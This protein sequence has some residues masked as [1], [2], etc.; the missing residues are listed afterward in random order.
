[1]KILAL[2]GSPRRSGNTDMLLEQAMA[3]AKNAGAEVEHVILSRLQ[4][5]PCIECNRCFKTG[6][7]AVQDDYQ[8][9]YDKTLQADGI[10]LASPI[11]FMNVTG[12]TK[13]FIDRF[14]CLWALR[15]VLQQPVPP[16]PG[17]GSRRAIFLSTAGGPT[18]R[19]DCAKSVVRA[20][21]DTIEAKLV[22]TL[23]ANAVDDKGDIAKHPELLEQAY[24][25]GALLASGDEPGRSA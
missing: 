3:G 14:Q 19:F 21:L 7:C 20:F 2:A 9:L 4:I 22:G 13:A 1:M 25:L 6:R 10:M 15:Y 23:C 16:P 12:F 8:A 5:A 17:V 11:F 24:A 18:T